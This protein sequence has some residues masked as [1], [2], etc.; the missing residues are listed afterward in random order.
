MTHPITLTITGPGHALSGFRYF[1]LKHVTGF[2]L[3]QHCARCLIGRYDRQVTKDMPLNEV[4]VLESPLVYLCGVSPR[5]PTNFHAAVEHAPG[6]SF[7]LPT[8]NGLTV[9]FTNGRRLPIPALA[10]G[11][12]GLTAAYTDC[13]NF[14]FAVHRYGSSAES[15][16]A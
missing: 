13:R 16:S 8:Y 11:Y 10:R 9:R 2:D 3:A 15:T 4:V 14:Q 7:D 1:W 12:G 6:E 5:Y